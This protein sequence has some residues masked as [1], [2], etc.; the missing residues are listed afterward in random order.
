MQPEP[1][2]ITVTA[3]GPSTMTEAQAYRAVR[4]L[5]INELG[6]T[7]EGIRKMIDEIVMKEIRASLTSAATTKNIHLLIEKA[8]T[9]AFAGYFGN[10]RNNNP[11]TLLNNHIA[12][13]IGKQITE[14]LKKRLYIAT[15]VEELADV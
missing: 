6:L 5:T 7:R 13:E 12:A 10:I 8:V 1:S 2:T 4:N 11:K 15:T 9:D 3:A 14:M